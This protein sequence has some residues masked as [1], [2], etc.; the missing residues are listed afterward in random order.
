MTLGE[1]NMV[2]LMTDRIC[3]VTGA[4]SGIGLVTARTLAH[5]G[6][7]VVAVGRNPEKGAAIVNEIK[8]QVGNS[9]VDFLQADLSSQQDIR[10]L[11]GTFRERYSN[12]HVLV[13]NAGATFGKRQESIDGLEMTF[14]LNHLGY[15]LLTNLLLATMKASVPARII[16]VASEVHAWR[17]QIDFADLQGQRRYSEMGAYAQ[18][19]LANV[20]F[21]YEL[22]RRLSCD[23][24]VQGLTVN[25]MNPGVVKTNFQMQSGVW[26]KLSKMMANAFVG[27]D[28][29]KGAETILYLATSPRVE[30]VTG[31]YFEKGKEVNSS[32]ASYD[33][34][35]AHQLWQMSAKLTGLEMSV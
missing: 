34:A 6:A 26:S 14:A 9:S 3:M 13:N 31:R 19:K 27:I 22:A 21:T 29:E 18:S 15:F 7:T 17:K 1:K 20:L 33:E 11:V 32:K 25:A 12:L 10:R 24:S 8:R 23:L 2:Q 5:H 30:K 28:V 35:T 16:N 4:T